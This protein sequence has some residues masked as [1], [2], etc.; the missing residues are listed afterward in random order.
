MINYYRF[1]RILATIITAMYLRI[2]PWPDWFAIMNPDWILL[3]LIYWTMAVPE[4]F[5]IF[6]AWAIGLLT[7]VLTGNLF[8]QHSFAYSLVSY[9]CLVMHKRLRQFP[10]FQQE[11]FIFLFLLSS[12]L[13]L[14]W[15]QNIESRGSLGLNFWLPLITGTLCWPLVYKIL[16]F[17]RL[18]QANA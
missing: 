11:W 8:G 12:Q 15:L 4:R 6:H 14:Y 10:I 1:G 9:L 2:A 17:I 5:G 18:L 13:I 16:R 3:S 7:D